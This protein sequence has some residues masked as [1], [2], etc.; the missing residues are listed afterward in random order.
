MDKLM[1]ILAIITGREE[2]DYPIYRKGALNFDNMNYVIDFSAS[3][4]Y[5]ELPAAR[6]SINTNKI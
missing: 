3:S 1:D 6:R 4:H 5:F 2:V